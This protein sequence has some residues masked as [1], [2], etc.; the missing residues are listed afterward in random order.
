VE[1]ATVLPVL[2]LLFMGGMAASQQI[3]LQQN[4]HLLAS[5]AALQAIDGERSLAKIEQWTK[6]YSAELGVT[7][8]EVSLT[9]ISEQ[10]VAADISFPY[11]R[12]APFGVVR[13]TNEINARAVA[14]R[15]PDVTD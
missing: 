8:V 7:G 13:F 5:T 14:I 12:N 3:S 2:V 1:L 6:N 4:A 9:R 10:E 11:G 15:S